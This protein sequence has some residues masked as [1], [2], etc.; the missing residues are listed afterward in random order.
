MTIERLVAFVGGSRE[1]AGNPAALF[2]P[3]NPRGGNAPWAVRGRPA[4]DAQAR[5]SSL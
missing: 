3:R 4:Y 5:S 2:H 1:N